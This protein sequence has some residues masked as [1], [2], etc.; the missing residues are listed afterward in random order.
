MQRE[1]AKREQRGEEVAVKPFI[2]LPE[3]KPADEPAQEE[4]EEK[5][6]EPPSEVQQKV[7]MLGKEAQAIEQQ[8]R[9][10]LSASE[11]MRETYHQQLQQIAQAKALLANQSQAKVSAAEVLK[12]TTGGI[13]ERK[14]EL[15]QL[16]AE[17]E[18][19][20][21]EVPKVKRLQHKVTPISRSIKQQEEFH[22]QLVDNKVA[23]IPFQDLLDRLKTE[24]ERHKEWLAKNQQHYGVAGPIQGFSLQYVLER[25]PMSSVDQA[26]MG[27]GY[28]RISVANFKIIPSGEVAAESME[29]AL[30][31]NSRF[32]KA[33][34]RAPPDANMTFWVYPDSFKIYRRLQAATHDLG[35]S[36]AARPL[37]PGVP[38]CGSPNGTKSAGQ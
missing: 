11:E 16:L 36:V 37:P 6:L 22:F 38:I 18:Q 8:I 32:M 5:Y 23:F 2:P 33:L 1:I 34:R 28:Y 20:Q 30:Q 17:L 24:A 29:E 4:A 19:L 31:P 15:S 26:R 27:Q 13:E 14:Q 10:Q 9:K 21:K 3:T 35:F 7:A 12:P 25:V